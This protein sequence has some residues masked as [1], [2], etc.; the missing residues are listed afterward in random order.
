MN[1]FDHG[2]RDQ[3]TKQ[4]RSQQEVVQLEKLRLKNPKMVVLSKNGRKGGLLH[5][6]QT[7]VPRIPPS[8]LLRQLR[9]LRE[10]GLVYGKLNNDSSG[11]ISKVC[12]HDQGR[13]A[14]AHRMVYGS[15]ANN[16][17]EVAVEHDVSPETV[18]AASSGY[19]LVDGE[20]LFL[21]SDGSVCRVSQDRATSCSCKFKHH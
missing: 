12:L 7:F 19:F 11:S 3:S 4:S 2:F 9:A 15:Y 16:V 21:H 18:I 17:V 5:K 6:K 14:D 20:T 13:V 10:K 1:V 8:Y